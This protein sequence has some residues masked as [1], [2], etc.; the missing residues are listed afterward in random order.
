[1]ILEWAGKGEAGKPTSPTSVPSSLPETSPPTPDQSSL[2]S[3]AQHAFCQFP[4]EQFSPA[5]TLHN[6][7]TRVNAFEL[8]RAGVILSLLL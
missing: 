5:W 4:W 7:L 1:M 8:D 6:T 2:V 3:S